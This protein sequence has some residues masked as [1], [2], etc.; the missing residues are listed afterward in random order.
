M[1][2]T[3]FAY[4]LIVATLA[5]GACVSCVSCVFGNGDARL[6]VPVEPLMVVAI[7]IGIRLWHADVSAAKGSV[8]HDIVRE[9]TDAAALSSN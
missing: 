9:G 6:R 5:Y 4:W 3:R 7:A 1:N 2:L 8:T